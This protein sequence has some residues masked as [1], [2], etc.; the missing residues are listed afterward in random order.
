[1]GVVVRKDKAAAAGVAA[2]LDMLEA[3]PAPELEPAASPATFLAGVSK[4]LKVSTDVDADL[5]S[6]LSNHLLTIM[7][8]ANAVANAKAAIVALAAKRA[9]SAVEQSDV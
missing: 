7:P 3:L 6:L 1:M 2:S 4:A 5:A 9:A 8:H